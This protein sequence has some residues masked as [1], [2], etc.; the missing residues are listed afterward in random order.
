MAETPEFAR[1]YVN[2]ASAR[3]GAK[4]GAA[5]DDFFADKSRLIDDAEPL[6]HPDRYD[7]HG[8]W[9]DGWETRRRRS[10]GHDHCE[11]IL[12]ALARL[13]GVCIDTAFF[14]GNFPPAASLAGA[15]G[16]AWRE[17]LPASALNGNAKHYF[18]L[19]DGPPVE[20]VRLNIY[21][22]GGVAR[23]RLYG[24]P[25]ID[26][27]RLKAS[28]ET[29]ELSS[30]MLGARIIGFSDAHYGT[31]WSL[32]APDRA[33]N[34]GD[35]WETRRRRTPGNDWIV[36]AL[37][38]RGVVERV[39]VDTTFFKG[40]FPEAF[41]LQAADVPALPDAAVINEAMFW[42]EILGRKELSADAIRKFDLG[43][44][45]GA[46]VSHVRM[47]IYPDGGVSRL[48]IFGKVPAP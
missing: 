33:K 5:S 6:F 43:P 1:R 34:M 16:G 31:L 3:L 20:R 8:K 42:P 18:L 35:G 10:G 29:V 39:E 47:N 11:V 44:G 38:A 14:T 4:V 12:G 26:W 27:E 40:N 46:P 2:L 9:M 23:L 15:A 25:A 30:V 36:I 21:P 7:D 13:K 41:S 48:R 45:A 19:A 32:L 28:R 37:G 24:E 17:L 22:D